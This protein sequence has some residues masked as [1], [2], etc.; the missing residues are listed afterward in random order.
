[1]DEDVVALPRGDHQRVRH[2][3]ILQLE[4]VL[5]DHLEVVPV[6]VHRVDSWPWST[7]PWSCGD[8]EDGGA[9]RLDLGVTFVPSGVSTANVCGD[10][11]AV[12]DVEVQRLVLRGVSRPG[13]ILKSESVTEIVVLPPAACSPPPLASPEPPV[14]VAAT[15]ADASTTPRTIHLRAR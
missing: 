6:Q 11:T 13:W 14:Q 8:L 2:V 7:W 4:A 12:R 1:V 10:F 15:R 9:P 3:G 5:G